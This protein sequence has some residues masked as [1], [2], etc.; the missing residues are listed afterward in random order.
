[1]NILDVIME[2]LG[3][4]ATWHLEFGQAW[5]RE[6]STGK[7]RK[8]SRGHMDMMKDIDCLQRRNPGRTDTRWSVMHQDSEQVPS[9]LV[10][11]IIRL[12]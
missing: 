9:G 2:I 4:K 6:H 12:I 8:Q 1:M 11:K 10:H 7:Y 5:F 3:T